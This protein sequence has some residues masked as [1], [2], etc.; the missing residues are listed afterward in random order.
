MLLWRLGPKRHCGFLVG[1][2]LLSLALSEEE[3]MPG[4]IHEER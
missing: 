4:D 2:C 3:G 1:Y